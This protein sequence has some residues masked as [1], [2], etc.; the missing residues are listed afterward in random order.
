M[1]QA[2]FHHHLFDAAILGQYVIIMIP[3]ER[4]FSGNPKPNQ[5]NHHYAYG[6]PPILIAE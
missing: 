4:Q 2:P 1:A 5:R 3:I 6:N